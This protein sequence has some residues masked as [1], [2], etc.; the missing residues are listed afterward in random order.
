MSSPY[1]FLYTRPTERLGGTL[2]VQTG[3]AAV[4]YPADYLD[5]NQPHLPAKLVETSGAWTRDLG[6]PMQVD[7]C[8]VIHHNLNV[9]VVVRLQGHGSNVWTSPDVDLTL[10]LPPPH[11]DG[12]TCNLWVDVAKAVPLAASR[13]KQWWRLVVMTVNTA[14]V[15]V[16]EWAMYSTVRNLGIR[17]ISKGSQRRVHRPSIIH[18]TELLVRRSYDLGTSLRSVQVSVESTDLYRADIEEWWRSANGEVKPFVI[19]PNRDE[20]EA[21]FVT[22]LEPVLEWAREHKNYNPLGLEFREV[23][24]GLTL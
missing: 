8:A 23:S 10:V 19:V 13:T 1:P 22:F 7:F 17:N 16:G 6:A 24:R 9:G 14:P 11:A 20:D 4:G 18:E 15:A 2:A 5:D 3:T 12:F 21:W